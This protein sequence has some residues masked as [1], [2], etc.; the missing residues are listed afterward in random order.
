[1]EVPEADSMAA[2][3]VGLTAEEAEASTE[4]DRLAGRE[5]GLADLGAVARSGARADSADLAEVHSADREAAIHSGARAVSAG[6]AADRS[7]A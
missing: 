6:R 7:E 5:E 4:A 1:M 3:E 2:V